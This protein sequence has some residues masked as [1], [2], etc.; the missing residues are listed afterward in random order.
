[1][2]LLL[3]HH[4]VRSTCLAAPEMPRTSFVAAGSPDISVFKALNS[5]VQ[6]PIWRAPAPLCSAFKTQLTS[7]LLWGCPPH[8]RGR[9]WARSPGLR[10]VPGGGGRD[11]SYTLPTSWRADTPAE[12][13]PHSHCPSRGPT[14]C[15]IAA[16]GTSE[17]D[18]EEKRAV[19]PPLSSSGCSPSL[20]ECCFCI[21]SPRGG[22]WVGCAGLGGGSRLW[23]CCPL[24]LWGP[25]SAAAT[26]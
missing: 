4:W 2:P 13:P 7:L 15:S 22:C 6:V 5:H 20:H 25:G 12:S 16:G 3:G 8:L 17:S 24:R 18:W 10:S 21:C 23:S 19:R 1:M 26:G 11:S 14:W 9:L